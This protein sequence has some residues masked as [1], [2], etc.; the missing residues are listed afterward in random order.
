[1][2]EDSGWSSFHKKTW[3][4]FG[5]FIWIIPVLFKLHASFGNPFLGQRFCPSCQG[6]L[7]S[8]TTVGFF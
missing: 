7:V 5:D 4:N 2:D 8:Y 6:L 3:E 1:V